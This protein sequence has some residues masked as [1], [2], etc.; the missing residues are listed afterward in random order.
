MS[1][2]CEIYETVWL[3]Q[4]FGAVP[5]HLTRTHTHPPSTC[6]TARD[7]YSYPEF[8]PVTSCQLLWPALLS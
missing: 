6:S 4:D 3:N 5:P 8:V 2:A 7:V 1:T